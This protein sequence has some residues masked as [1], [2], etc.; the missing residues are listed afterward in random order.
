M[1]LTAYNPKM[2]RSGHT[3]WVSVKFDGWRLM[4]HYRNGMLLFKSRSGKDIDVPEHIREELENLMLGG[5]PDGTILDGELWLREQSF[6]ETSAAIKQKSPDLK[7]LVFDMPSAPGGFSGRLQELQRLFERS[8]DVKAV[9]LVSH[10]PVTNV[11]K[12]DEIFEA[13][14][15]LKAEG[16]V[17]RPD[18]LQYQWGARPTNFMKRKPSLD[19]EVT[20]VGHK[21]TGKAPQ[22]NLDYISS[23]VCEI[24]GETFSVP[25]KACN[26]PPIGTTVTVTCPELTMRGVPK[27]A[28]YKGVREAADMPRIRVMPQPRPRITLQPRV[29]PQP[30]PCITPHVFDDAPLTPP[31]SKPKAKPDDAPLTTSKFVVGQKFTVPSSKGTGSHQLKFHGDHWFCSCPAWKYQKRNPKERTCKHINAFLTTH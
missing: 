1:L 12:I 8:D 27:H 28:V 16:I 9:K 3:Y 11:P 7:Y 2:I 4:V 25:F 19:F 14:I 10:C 23:L 29:T 30:R 15:R 13:C 24:G 26:A 6:E 31:R 17:I 22:G 5:A 20:V 21:R 18:D